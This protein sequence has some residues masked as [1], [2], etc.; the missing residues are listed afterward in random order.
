[1]PEQF[2]LN[3]NLDL[4][5]RSLETKKD[6]PENSQPIKSS[7]CGKQFDE[8]VSPKIIKFSTDSATIDSLAST[9]IDKLVKYAKVCPNSI[10]EVGGHTDSRGNEA[11][12]YL[13]SKQ[14]AQTIVSSLVKSGIRTGRLVVQGYGESRPLSDNSTEKGQAQN[15][16]IEF[17]YL[18]EGE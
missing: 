16:R 7:L 1:L 6:E 2:V 11:H 17:K 10:I 5:Q 14:R 4:P 9:V 13:L 15:R 8:L 3:L 18:R 12:N